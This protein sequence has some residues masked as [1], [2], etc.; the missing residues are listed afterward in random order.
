[1]R[2]F[3]QQQNPTASFGVGILFSAGTTEN[4]TGATILSVT[5]GL[6][7]TSGTPF[8]WEGYSGTTAFNLDDL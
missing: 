5:V 4:D 8:V 2:G 3:P 6:S 7:A 1:M